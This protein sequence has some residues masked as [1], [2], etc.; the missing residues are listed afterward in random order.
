M[1][2]PMLDSRHCAPGALRREKSA[3]TR[4]RA[5]AHAGLPVLLTIAVLISGCR[6]PQG[7]GSDAAAG[8]PHARIEIVDVSADMPDGRTR[9]GSGVNVTATARNVSTAEA[10]AA[11]WEFVVY[12][13]REPA[14]GAQQMR[15]ATAPGPAI[16]AGEELSGAFAIEAMPDVAPGRYYLL[17]RAEVPDGAETVSAGPAKALEFLMLDP[18]YSR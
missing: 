7:T 11:A 16:A 18:V 5:P 8:A 9:A 4:S 15:L 14:I 3:A 10:P 12:L 1:I 13:S 2:T 6:A 17:V